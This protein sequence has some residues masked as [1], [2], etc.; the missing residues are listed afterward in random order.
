MPWNVNSIPEIHESMAQY[1]EIQRSVLLIRLANE[2]DDYRDFG[3]LHTKDPDKRLNIVKSCGDLV[4]SI[5]AELDYSYLASELSRAF[6]ECIVVDLDQLPCGMGQYSY[7]LPPKT[8]RRT[9]ALAIR[10]LLAKLRRSLRQTA[11]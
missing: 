6:S 3:A 10:N 11:R 8:Y 5:A 9:P 4:V 1:D 7:I 2:V